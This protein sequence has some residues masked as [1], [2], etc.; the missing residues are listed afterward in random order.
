MAKA[1][2]QYSYEVNISGEAASRP[3]YKRI[4]AKDANLKESW[5]RDAIFD[6]PELVID[7]CREAGLVD[8]SE[9]WYAWAREFNLD[10]G[11]V[12]VLLLSSRGRIGIV[13]T[14][15]SFNPERRREVVAQVCDY[16]LALQEKSYEEL[17]EKPIINNT[18]L[19][20]ENDI[21]ESL[22]LGNFLLI[23]AGDQI[24]PRALR[25]GNAILAGHLTS[26]WDL[27]MVDMNLFVDTTSQPPRHLMIPELRGKLVVET[28]Q[29]VRVIVQG[30]KPEAKIKVERI[31]PPRPDPT[32]RFSWDYESFFAELA[33]ANVSQAFRDFAERVS[34]LPKHYSGISIRYGVGKKALFTVS[35]SGKSI[36]SLIMDGRVELKPRQFIVDALG[37]DGASEYLSAIEQY[38]GLGPEYFDSSSLPKVPADK[39]AAHANQILA[40][41]EKAFTMGD[42][43]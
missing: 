26:E 41:L 13:E 39:V 28:R 30:E 29:V 33:S 3:V 42:K 21:R 11:P 14:K 40:V 22:A 15:L 24:D 20:T 19:P 1:I 8:E 34:E 32:E 37:V 35:K 12:D 16:A 9:S 31:I 25:L 7:V 38:W 2:G 6:N 23:I 18:E 5:F 36:I 17:P 4:L 27:A 43:T 10:A